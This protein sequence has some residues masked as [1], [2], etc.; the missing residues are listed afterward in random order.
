MTASKQDQLLV[1]WFCI[2]ERGEDT[3]KPMR[4]RV[5][6]V[7]PSDAARRSSR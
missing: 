1:D 3:A 6:R 5:K 7:C 2:P 4:E